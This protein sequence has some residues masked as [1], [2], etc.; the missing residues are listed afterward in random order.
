MRSRRKA[1]KEHAH[2]RETCRQ[3]RSWKSFLYLFVDAATEANKAY[4]L[5]SERDTHTA[6]ASN[7]GKWL[8][9]FLYCMRAAET[10]SEWGAPTKRQI[11]ILTVF[12]HIRSSFQSFPCRRERALSLSLSPWPGVPPLTTDGAERKLFARAEVREKLLMCTGFCSDRELRA[13]ERTQRARASGVFIELEFINPPGRAVMRYRPW[14]APFWSPALAP[15][16]A[17]TRQLGELRC[18]AGCII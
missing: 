13:R 11:R 17:I 4:K 1:A 8:G 16:F 6:A 3:T 7:A 2:L 9:C 12:V 14:L 10:E 18:A 15:G 5:Q